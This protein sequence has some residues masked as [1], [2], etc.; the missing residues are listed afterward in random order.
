M[1]IDCPSQALKGLMIGD[2]VHIA[3]CG[4]C[5]LKSSWNSHGAVFFTVPFSVAGDVKSLLP[6]IR[7]NLLQ[8]RPELFMQGDTVSVVLHFLWVPFKKTQKQKTNNN[9]QNPQKHKNIHQSN[10]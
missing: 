5:D 8:E 3:V 2:S 4:L 1:Q 10:S 7:D 9:K 6:W